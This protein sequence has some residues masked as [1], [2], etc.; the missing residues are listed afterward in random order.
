[1][2]ANGKPHVLFVFYSFTEQTRRV[3]DTMADVLR[4]R[5]FDVTEAPIEFSDEH[6]GKR[7][8]K[9]PMDW[10]VMKIFS[11]LP[12]QARKKTGT[13]TIPTEASEGAYDLVVVGSPT[14]WL[15]ACMPV[16]SYMHDPAAQRVLG[17]KPFAAFST[18]R[19]Y[20]K[21]TLKTI[22]QLGEKSG[23]QFIDETHF[24]ADGNQVTSMWSWLAFMRH[25]AVQE[26]SLGFRLPKP[27]LRVGFEEQATGFINALAD[28]VFESES[29][30]GT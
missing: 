22:R 21:G 7:F 15:T 24:V 12:S 28:K 1:V 3:A 14:W 16:R 20:Y 11:M 9:R 30:S 17:G 29:T 2:T 23:G 8:S 13:I 4:G 18:S 26:R 27:N 19:R 10:P 25:D 5:G 6:Y